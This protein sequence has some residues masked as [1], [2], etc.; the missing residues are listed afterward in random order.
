MVVGAGLTILVQSSSV[1]TSPSPPWPAP[2][3]SPSTG[4][5]PLPSHSWLD[6]YK[7]Y[8]YDRIGHDL[9]DFGNM[10]EGKQLSLNYIHLQTY[11]HIVLYHMARAKH[12]RM[13]IIKKHFN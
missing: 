11:A 9:G 2:G 8:Y 13:D 6:D 3:S 4:P 7:M 10:H 1:F 12:I 5:T